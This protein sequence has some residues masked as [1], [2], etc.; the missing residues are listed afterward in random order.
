MTNDVLN[1]TIR[2]KYDIP[3]IEGLSL[4]GFASFS[5]VNQ[6]RKEFNYVWPYWEKNSEGEIVERV[7]RSVED[8]GLREDYDRSG[9]Y[10]LNIKL[11]YNRIFGDLHDIHAFVAYEQMES[12]DN[13]F[14]TQR[15]GYDSPAIDQL[16]AGS[17]NRAN[18]NN[19]GSAS[20]SARQNFFGRATYNY[21]G[22]YMLGFN[23]RYDG[24]PI[25]PEETRFG[26]FPGVSAG[27]VISK[28]S[29]MS[30]NVFNHL[31]LRAS[32]GQTGNDRVDPFQ[33]IG[34]Y[35]YGPGY[36]IDGNDVRGLQASTTPNPYITWEVSDNTNIGLET[37]FL[38]GRLTLSLMFSRSQ[39]QIYSGKDNLQSL[40]ILA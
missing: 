24:S 25:F 29:F 18:Y 40:S 23:F 13:Y 35:E 4:D 11:D 26:F 20:E 28:E 1:G 30:G 21:A 5:K 39:L 15:L 10:T 38:M 32:W 8:I 6:Y 19:S 31:K 37:G 14:W 34:V 17:T 33:Y 12:N 2:F 3:G 36:V 9:M 27:W 7:S 16:F 22:K